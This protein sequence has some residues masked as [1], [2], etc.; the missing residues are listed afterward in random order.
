[1][2]FLSTDTYSFKCIYCEE[3]FKRSLCA[4]KEKNYLFQIIK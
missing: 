1:M 4:A 3:K 2:W